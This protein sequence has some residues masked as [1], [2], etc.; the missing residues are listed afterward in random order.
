MLTLK[1]C[2]NKGHLQDPGYTSALEKMR[3]KCYHIMQILHLQFLHLRI[4]E[5]QVWIPD[6]ISSSDDMMLQMLQ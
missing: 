1:S 5:I 3:K 4:Y 6:S 2:E